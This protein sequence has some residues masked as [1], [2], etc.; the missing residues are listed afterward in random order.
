MRAL[1]LV[2]LAA[3]GVAE[4][5]REL[6]M[7]HCGL[8]STTKVTEELRRSQRPVLIIIQTI[9]PTKS[10]ICRGLRSDW[11]EGLGQCLQKLTGLRVMVRNDD[12]SCSD[13]ETLR[14]TPCDMTSPPGLVI[15]VGGGE[16]P[17]KTLRFQCT[18]SYCRQ[19][20][21]SRSFAVQTGE[22]FPPHDYV[23]ACDVYAYDRRGHPIF[24]E[25]WTNTSLFRQE[26]SSLVRR[27]RRRG[28][29]EEDSS[30]ERLLMR[31]LR[32]RE[33]GKIMSPRIV[34][35][36][37]VSPQSEI[38]ALWERSTLYAARD[39]ASREEPLIPARK[40]RYPKQ[41][42]SPALSDYQY[43]KN[44]VEPMLENKGKMPLDLVRD[45]AYAKPL[46]L[47]TIE[48]GLY[49]AVGE[50]PWT[51]R[52]PR[53]IYAGHYRRTKGQVDFL[54]MLDP[55]SLGPFTIELYGTRPINGSLGDD[56]DLI[57]DI[58]KA[59]RLQGKVVAFEDRIS[60]LKLMGKL[61]SA[62]GLVHFANSDRNPRIL[63][64]ALYFGLPLF[65]TIQSMPYVGLQC[66]NFVTL[67]D[68]DDTAD[69]MNAQFQ[70][71]TNILL[72]NEQRK[73]TI[74]ANK[75]GVRGLQQE[76]RDYVEANIVPAGVYSN[77]C[78]RFGL[79]AALE[80][81]SAD[82]R[83]PWASPDK[84]CGTTVPLRRYNNWE[85]SLWNASKRV[86]VAL[87]ISTSRECKKLHKT[88]DNCQDQCHV[89]SAIDRKRDQ[90]R[91]WWLP[92]Y[93]ATNPAPDY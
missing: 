44:T 13:C 53:L 58:I 92:R 36:P 32:Q 24:N 89:L 39:L 76:I 87:N 42:E 82:V 70:Q 57:H 5:E 60:H 28:L 23:G 8:S 78:Q 16:D 52:E 46:L 1:W 59:K 65:V 6:T 40:P 12:G 27:Q 33:K 34:W 35:F 77:L 93:V 19:D 91:P 81:H 41:M 47:P 45:D 54:R 21:F 74:A 9:T 48:R 66:Q 22:G 84:P 2:G 72:T 50:N 80:K 73:K 29:G 18:S 62:S 15:V 49:R 14:E 85:T 71:W 26:Y 90:R 68:A 63:Y 75:T 55:K 79:C 7:A 88:T 69:A 83:T 67:A 61:A 51:A 38:R 86:R 37:I 3:A 30:E 17:H 10:N 4:K 31:H 56:W 25:E 11:R 64:E 43:L 20:D